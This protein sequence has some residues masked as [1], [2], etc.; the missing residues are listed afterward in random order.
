MINEPTFSI[1]ILLGLGHQKS[2]IWVLMANENLAFCL[3]CFLMGKTRNPKKQI[4]AES[5]KQ[6]FESTKLPR[7]YRTILKFQQN[8]DK[9]KQNQP[10]V[11]VKPNKTTGEQIDEIR[12]MVNLTAK[13]ETRKYQKRKEYLVKKK[14]KRKQTP[15]ELD[16]GLELEKTL[17][18]KVAFGEQVM[19]PPKI[20]T[21]PKPSKK[22]LV[23]KSVLKD[24]GIV[25]NHS[26]KHNVDEVEGPKRKMRLRDMAEADKKSLLLEREK[27]IQLYRTNHQLA[28]ELKK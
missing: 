17:V 25:D 1:L 26:K 10:T 8:L 2:I 9:K 21:V 3:F 16:R 11:K 18:D 15:E 28:K 22:L 24:G 13:K 19:A 27:L 6:D 14:T 23:T 5:F 4:I 7:K 12:D 20:T